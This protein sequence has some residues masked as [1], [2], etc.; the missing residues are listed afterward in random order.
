MTAPYR[1]SWCL[2]KRDNHRLAKA[3]LLFAHVTSVTL[4]VP[5]LEAHREGTLPWSY[6]DALSNEPKAAPEVGAGVLTSKIIREAQCP[7][8]QPTFL[9]LSWAGKPSSPRTE[10]QP[11]MFSLVPPLLHHP[12]HRCGA[13]PAPELPPGSAPQGRPQ[14]YIKK[15]RIELRSGK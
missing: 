8:L 11:P 14:A 4:P 5:R 2:T 6:P 10:S 9:S 3:L 12:S 15:H 13:S 7:S 1:D